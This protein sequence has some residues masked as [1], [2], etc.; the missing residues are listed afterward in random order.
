MSIGQRRQGETFAEWHRIVACGARAWEHVGT[1]SPWVYSAHVV[2]S[3]SQMCAQTWHGAFNSHCKQWTAQAKSETQ[4]Q[5]VGG[6]PCAMK[7]T[8]GDR[9]I[10]LHC[11]AAA[12]FLPFGHQWDNRETKKVRRHSSR[13]QHIGCRFQNNN[14]HINTSEQQEGLFK[15]FFQPSG[16]NRWRSRGIP[17]SIHEA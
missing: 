3:M 10:S 6:K 8:P 2:P 1:L 15:S 13:H 11:T 12:K 17:A 9:S 16:P 14:A 5:S 4:S 7:V